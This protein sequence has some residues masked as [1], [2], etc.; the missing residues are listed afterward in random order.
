MTAFWNDL[1]DRLKHRKSEDF[2]KM[3]VIVHDGGPRKTDGQPQLAWVR[4]TGGTDDLFSGVVLDRPARLRRVRKGSRISFLVPKSG[5]Y[6]LQVSSRYLEERS[7]WRLLMPCNQCGLS[8][9]FDPPSELVAEIFP[10]MTSEDLAQGFT[11]TT[12]CGWCGG[13]LVVRIK[14]THWP[15]TK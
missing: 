2:T 1:I 11:F 7:S 15:W 5:Q 10:A 3:Q 6:A 14:R 8:E 9:L 12:R 4:V 13:G